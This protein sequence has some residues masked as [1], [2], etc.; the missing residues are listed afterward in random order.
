MTTTGTTSDRRGRTAIL[1]GVTADLARLA[2]A[3]S[4]VSD[5]AL[6]TAQWPHHERPLHES[7]RSCPDPARGQR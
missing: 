1:D 2:W 7:A 3:L 4:G 6:V 5:P